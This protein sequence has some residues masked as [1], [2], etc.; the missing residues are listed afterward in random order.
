MALL[1]TATLAFEPLPLPFTTISG[2]RAGDGYVCF[3]ASSPTENSRLARLDLRTGLIVVLRRSSEQLPDPGYVATPQAIEF[4]TEHGLTAHAFFYPPRNPAFSGPAGEK[5]PLLVS[6]H[7]GPT[8]VVS[9]SLSLSTQ[10]WTSRG[11]AVVQVNYGG[12]TGY[13]RAYRERL[14]GQ[15]GGGRRGL[16]ERGAPPGGPGPGRREPDGNPRGS[17][18]G[19]RHCARWCST[20]SFVPA[21]YTMG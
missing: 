13:G 20:I 3:M 18:G 9:P 14:N 21:P 8:D 5:P 4:P 16:R 10:Y 17:A 6:C 2:V 7:G 19:Y 12:S 11:F 15:W 1:D